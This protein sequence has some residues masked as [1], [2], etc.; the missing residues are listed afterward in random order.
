MSVTPGV[1]S[2]Y[3]A[4]AKT[5]QADL[6]CPIDYDQRL[7]KLLPQEIIEKDYGCGDPRAMYAKA[8]WCSTSALVVERSVTWLLKL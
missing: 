3:S 2:R 1:M 4:A 6:C 7:L 5:P 8:M